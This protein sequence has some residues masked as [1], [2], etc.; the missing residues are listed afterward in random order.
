VFIDFTLPLNFINFDFLS[1]LMES[2]CSLAVSFLDQFVLHMLLP[3]VLLLGMGMA[4][5]ISRCCVRSSE[6]RKRGVEL[7][8]QMLILG[9]LLLYPG[10]ATRIFTVWRCKDIE[11]VHG[12]VMVADFA[13]QCDIG[14]HIVYSGIAFA[15][16]CLYII[17]IPLMMMVVLWRNRRH[18]HDETSNRHEIVK[19]SLGGLYLQYE[20][21]Y[22]VSVFH[23]RVEF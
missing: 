7:M 10:L 17:G 13:I 21:E 11:G 6:K 2:T 16:L 14:A 20:K 19:T 1:L 18:L 23:Q 4:F 8:S 5:G 3:V 22:W 12:R 9:V 15:C